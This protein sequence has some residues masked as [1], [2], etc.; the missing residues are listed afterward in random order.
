LEDVIR[1]RIGDKKLGFG[2]KQKDEKV[3]VLPDAGQLL[4][5]VEPEDLL[6]YG[7]IPEFI[8][9]LPIYVALT[10]LDEESLVKVLVEPKNALIKQ[11]NRLF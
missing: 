10:E 5:Q 2:A 3:T 9:R 1:R 6:K 7:L 11:Y 4:S 8:G